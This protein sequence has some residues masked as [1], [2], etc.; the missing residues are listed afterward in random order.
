[1]PAYLKIA[2][3]LVVAVVA[4]ALVA[5]PI[6]WA[7]QALAAGGVSDWLAGFPFH[8]VLSRC[9]QV[10]V[11]VLLWP[12]LR[13]IRLRHVRELNLQSNPVAG[14]D[15]S[16]GLLFS[17]VPILLL[18]GAYLALGFFSWHPEPEWTR[19]GRI[20]LTAV[21]V[22]GI[23]EAVFRGVVLGLCLWTLRP[24]G[25]LVVSSLFFAV[26]HFLKP[27]R[28]D[29][30]AAEV[31]W[32]TGLA[33]VL[34]FPAAWPSGGLVV[35][36]LVSL[37]AA[38]WILGTAALRTRSL[39]L[40]IGLHAGWIFGQQCSQV[41]LRP[42]PDDAVMLLPWAGPNLVSGAVPTGLLPLAA[43]LLGGLLVHLYLRHVFRP[44][45]R[46]IS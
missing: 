46:S 29:V 2:V 25:A 15:L 27:A 4:G 44:M 45:V 43:V 39:W 17:L 6:Y 19:G 21:A 14:R 12:A 22:S 24:A 18:V 38:G 16:A 1:M 28:S 31:G 35:W 9:I 23:E 20:L 34:S 32:S 26:V 40:P 3:Y 11:L 36:G 8:R 41:V 42:V 33:E 10:S 37:F 13:W 30:A 7:G 5:P